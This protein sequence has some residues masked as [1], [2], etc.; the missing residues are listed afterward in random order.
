MQGKNLLGLHRI[1]MGFLREDSKMRKGERF[2]E[3]ER[4]EGSKRVH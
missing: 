1:S 3:F 2:G 4:E